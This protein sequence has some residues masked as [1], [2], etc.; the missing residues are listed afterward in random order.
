[1]STENEVQAKMELPLMASRGAII[2]PHMVIPLLVGREKSKVALEEAMMEEKKII[3]VAQKDEAIE[4][5]EI[6]DIYEFGTIAQIKQ[7]V[8]LPNGM[9]KVVIEGLERAELSNYLK[10]EEYFRVEVKTQLEAEIEV[11]TEIKALMRT[12]IKEF[13]NYIKYHNDLPGETIMAASN[14]EEPGQLADVIASHTEL[15]YQDLQKILEITDIVERLEKLLSL[16]QSEIEVLKIEQD[17]N[18][19]VKNKVEKNQKEYYLREKMKIIKDE[20]DQDQDS[21]DEIEAYYQKLEELE[22][23]EKVEEKIEEEI[24]N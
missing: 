10:T 1:M 17:I 18:K 14:I 19:R 2:F 6:S 13:E 21:N 9:I 8:K 23:P 16:L 3:I 20:L 7:L 24:K 12:V 15:K 22:L 11:S 5:P 4:E